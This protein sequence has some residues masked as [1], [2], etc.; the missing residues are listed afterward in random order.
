MTNLARKEIND[1]IKLISVNFSNLLERKSL[2]Q[3]EGSSKELIYTILEKANDNAVSSNKLYNDIKTSI[4]D[5]ESIYSTYK[6]KFNL[7]NKYKVITEDHINDI[8][9]PYEGLN[10]LKKSSIPTSYVVFLCISIIIATI[11]ILS[12]IFGIYFDFW[13]INVWI[14]IFLAI[15]SIGMI[16]TVIAAIYEWRKKLSEKMAKGYNR[17]GKSKIK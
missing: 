9:I 17:E 4:S 10:V 2:N 5:W 16:A 13:V 1:E 12:I 6:E 7:D 14:N 15:G 8:Y 11:S 3:L